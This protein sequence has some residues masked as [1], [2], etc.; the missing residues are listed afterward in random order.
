MKH[1]KCVQQHLLLYEKMVESGVDE[2]VEEAIM[3]NKDW[4]RNYN[5]AKEMVIVNQHTIDF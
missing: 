1:Q 4:V 2:A 3:Y 5:D